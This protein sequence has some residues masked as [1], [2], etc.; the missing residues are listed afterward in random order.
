M[1]IL[2][3]QTL[4]TSMFIILGKN[5]FYQCQIQP[6]DRS[7]T[8]LFTSKKI[9]FVVNKLKKWEIWKE[10]KKGIDPKQVK[11]QGIPGLKYL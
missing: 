8:S 6:L 4:H 11:R 5:S 3:G 1:K 7:M 9:Y 2:L 10:R